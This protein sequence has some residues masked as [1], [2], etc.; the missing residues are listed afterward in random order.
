MVN[1]A[2]VLE[3]PDLSRFVSMGQTIE[4]AFPDVPCGI[5]PFGYRVV[6]QLRTPPKQTKGGIHLDVESRETE[7]WN[8]QIGKVVAL[9]PLA[10]CDRKTGAKWPE[11]SWASVG[12]FVRIGKYAGDRWEVP[13]PGDKNGD[14]ALFINVVDLELWGKVEGN[15]LDV[16]AYLWT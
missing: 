12:D 2:V 10:Y 3:K 8:T 9:G 11:G 4:E 13:I 7:K 6:I 16:R 5:Q 1:K 14:C 15:P